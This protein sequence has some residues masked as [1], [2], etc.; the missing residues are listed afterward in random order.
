MD[1]VI[2]ILP[3]VTKHLTISPRFTPCAY[4]KCN[5]VLKKCVW[6]LEYGYRQLTVYS[7]NCVHPTVIFVL[8]NV[9]YAYIQCVVCQG[10]GVVVRTCKLWTCKD[11]R[12]VLCAG[13]VVF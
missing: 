13:Y 10:L 4:L 9:T 11:F 12:G 3:A 8:S 1:L 5:R 7:S 2:T 6:R